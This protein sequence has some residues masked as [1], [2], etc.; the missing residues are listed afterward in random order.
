[1]RGIT[2]FF[3][4]MPEETNKAW[5]NKQYDGSAE[6][7]EEY[8]LEREAWAIR[9]DYEEHLTS[10]DPKQV[11]RVEETYTVPEHDEKDPHGPPGTEVPAESENRYNSR[12]QR[13]AKLGK[14]IWAEAIVGF[15]SEARR[16]VLSVA[17]YDAR[18]VFAGIEK[19]HGTKTSKQVTSIVR[20]FQKKTKK[21]SESIQTFNASWKDG[22]RI[23][24]STFISCRSEV[25]TARWKTWYR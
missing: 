24:S 8:E 11:P 9:K 4:Q 20:N 7:Y 14:K 1:L 17:K 15:N 5:P 19:Q 22:L 12:L 23:M 10:T 18:A 21:P 2:N 25:H 13:D 6:R 3:L 16:T